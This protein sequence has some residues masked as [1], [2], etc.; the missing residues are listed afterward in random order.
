MVMTAITAL[1]T[2]PITTHAAESAITSA[3]ADESSV[4]ARSIASFEGTSLDLSKS[5]GEAGACWIDEDGA[6]TCYR[7]E[8]EMDAAIVAAGGDLGRVTDEHHRQDIAHGARMASC[9]SSLRLY[10]SDSYSGGTLYLTQRYSWINLSWYGFDNDTSSYRVGACSTT[11]RSGS[12]GGG[13]TYW[14][15]TGAFASKSSMSGWNNV[16]SS[17]RIS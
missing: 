12:N 5:W 17:V 1:V 8:K 11:F 6:A 15:G 2:G 7:T 3:S 16:L 14:G 4:D 10:R 13:T 9:S